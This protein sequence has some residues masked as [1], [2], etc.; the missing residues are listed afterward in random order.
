MDKQ[1]D[2]GRT[3]N[4][5]WGG[6]KAGHK[7][8]HMQ[9]IRWA[10][11]TAYAGDKAGHMHATRHAGHKADQ[12]HGI[13]WTKWG[14]QTAGHRPDQM[15]WTNGRTWGGL[16]A[17]HQ[18]DHTQDIEDK[19]GPNA[20]PNAGHKAEQCGAQSG[21]TAWHEV[22]QLQDMGV[23]QMQ[24]TRWA[25]AGHQVDNMKYRRWTH[26]MYGP[27]TGHGVDQMAGHEVDQMHDMGQ[28]EHMT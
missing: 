6:Q 1:Q 4:T 28:T 17:G 8:D 7:V 13:M 3:K 11:C 27:N 19:G 24:E 20:G 14:V 15:G 9:D 5:T 18:V 12:L 2:I 25:N 10:Q 22:D 21:P 23:Y 26:C 16:Q